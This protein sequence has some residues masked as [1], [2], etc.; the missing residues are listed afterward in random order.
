M[1]AVPGPHECKGCGKSMH[2]VVRLAGFCYL[3]AK[4]KG[5]V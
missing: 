1:T 5:I 4:A 2:Y 3:C